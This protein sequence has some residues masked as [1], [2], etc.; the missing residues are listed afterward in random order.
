MAAAKSTKSF[1]IERL[2]VDLL[3]LWEYLARVEVVIVVI[4]VVVVIVIIIFIRCAHIYSSI[5]CEYGTIIHFVDVYLQ[6][7]SGR[8]GS[9]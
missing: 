6:S 5:L 4:V 9:A 1:S 8:G 3:S 2:C 7:Q